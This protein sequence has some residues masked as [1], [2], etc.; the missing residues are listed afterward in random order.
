MPVSSPPV[1]QAFDGKLAGV[2]AEPQVD[3]S[4]VAFQIVKTMRNDHAVSSMG[5][6]MVEHLHWIHRV[7]IPVAI[8]G[9]QQFFLRFFVELRALWF[10]KEEHAGLILGLHRQ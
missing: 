1:S 10:T 4:Q 7:Q 5:E 9:S 6:V 3:V 2:V 8:V